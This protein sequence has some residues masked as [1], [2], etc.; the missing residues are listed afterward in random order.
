M[1]DLDHIRLSYRE[2][3][4]DV[5]LTPKAAVEIVN[6]KQRTHPKESNKYREYQK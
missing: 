6:F 3:D 1:Q 4:E 2:V 5:N